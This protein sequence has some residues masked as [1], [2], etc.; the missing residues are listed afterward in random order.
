MSLHKRLLSFKYAFQGIALLFKSEANAQIHLLALT[1]V[2]LAGWF[3]EIS[4]TE[5]LAVLVISALILALEAVNTAIE[6]LT[7]L[8]SPQQNPLAGQVKDM[9]AGAVLLAAIFAVAVACIIFG[10]K[11]WSMCF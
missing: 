1:C 7:D 9:A 3:F 4:K 8:V 10:P 2:C 5:W 11:L 6:K